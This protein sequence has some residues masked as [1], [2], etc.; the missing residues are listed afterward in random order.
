MRC[1][2]GWPLEAAWTRHERHTGGV[3]RL[4]WLEGRFAS[5]GY[6]GDLVLAG[7]EGSEERRETFDAAGSLAS[8]GPDV[9]TIGLRTGELERGT[10]QSSV[11]TFQPTSW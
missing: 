11:S 6:E 3:A 4:L 2:R 8:A 1:Y 10:A 9:L 5:L 7:P